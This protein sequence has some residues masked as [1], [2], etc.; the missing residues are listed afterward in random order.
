[1]QFCDFGRAI[2]CD[3]QLLEINYIII[4]KE[5]LTKFCNIRFSRELKKIA[6]KKKL[7][8][9]KFSVGI[10][11]SWY[12][13]N[14]KSKLH[15]KIPL[16]LCLYIF[17]SFLILQMGWFCL[18]SVGDP[19]DQKTKQRLRLLQGKLFHLN[20]R[21]MQCIKYKYF[22]L[23]CALK[24]LTKYFIFDICIQTCQLSPFFILSHSITTRLP[25]S[26]FFGGKH[27]EIKLCLVE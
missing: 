21:Y 23:G 26:C 14:P 22:F 17:C 11:V 7:M 8:Q 13:I 12:T 27:S 10:F 5:I 16:S 24:Y 6:K 25:I 15:S 1:M 19:K 3:S 20:L 18:K 4:Q 9:Q 2:F